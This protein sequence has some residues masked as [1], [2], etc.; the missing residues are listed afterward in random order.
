MNYVPYV[1]WKSLTLCVLPRHGS[2]MTLLNL[3]APSVNTPVLD[4]TE[5]DM[6]VE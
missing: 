1:T 4:V 2:G 3:N 6:V 5:I